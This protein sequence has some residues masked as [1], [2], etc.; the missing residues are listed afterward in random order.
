M[1]LSVKSCYLK[2]WNQGCDHRSWTECRQSQHEEKWAKRQ[3]KGFH[4]TSGSD[5]SRINTSLV[6]TCE[7]QHCKLLTHAAV[8]FSQSVTLQ[9]PK[10]PA[11]QPVSYFAVPKVS[12]SSAS[13][14]LC[15]PQRLLQFSQSVTLQSPKSPTAQPVSYLAV[16]KVSYSSAN[17]LFCSPRSLLQLSQSVTLQ[18]PKSPQK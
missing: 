8:Q 12:Y 4:F 11:A 10:S 18:S 3:G 2:P 13:Q 15:S 5:N 14:L 17:H 7:Q 1:C 6:E 9:S 16:P